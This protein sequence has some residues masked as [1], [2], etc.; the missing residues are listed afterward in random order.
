M[1]SLSYNAVMHGKDEV[2]FAS[3][4]D[5]DQTAPCRSSLN[6]VFTVCSDQ[7]I[8]ILR[9]FGLGLACQG[10]HTKKSTLAKIFT[11]KKTSQSVKYRLPLC[12]K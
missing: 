9:I 10:C 5:T 11:K 7:S 2:C 4:V 8:T 3:S 1:L 12:Y 6:W